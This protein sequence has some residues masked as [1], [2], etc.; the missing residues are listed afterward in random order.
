V[1]Q[2]SEAVRPGSLDRRTVALV[3]VA[4]GARVAIDLSYAAAPHQVRLVPRRQL[5]HGALYRVVVTTGVRDLAGNRL[6]QS[7]TAAGRQA[8]SWTFRAG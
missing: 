8:A 7:A 3:R 5:R 2:L 6:D 1:V 4:T